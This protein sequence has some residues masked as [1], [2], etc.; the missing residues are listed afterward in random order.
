MTNTNSDLRIEARFRNNVLWHAIFDVYQTV[1]EF[2]RSHRF[3]ESYIGAILNLKKSPYYRDG[4]P[5]SM[6]VRISEATGIGVEELFPHDLY[7]NEAFRLRPVAEVS[8][9]QFL[10]LADPSIRTLAL[11][12]DPPRWETIEAI[13]SVL[14]TLTPREEKIIRARYGLED[15]VEQP[16]QQ[17]ADEWAVSVARIQQIEAKALR[18]LRHPSRARLL[19]PH[20]DIIERADQ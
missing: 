8:S 20:V 5:T 2:C 19:E 7:A 17:V 3:S 13:D 9:S 11:P 15:G 10:S 4:R 1:A 6:A 14:T 12:A 16:L 18:K